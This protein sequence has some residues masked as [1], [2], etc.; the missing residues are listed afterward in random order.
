M[1]LKSEKKATYKEEFKRLIGYPSA[2]AAHKDNK[3]AQTCY[4]CKRK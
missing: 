3:C 2:W 4:Y 1:S